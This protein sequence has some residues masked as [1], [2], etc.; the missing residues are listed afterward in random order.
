LT[1]PLIFDATPLIYLVKVSL[2]ESLRK[3]RTPKFL[4]QGVYEELLKGEPL[5]KPEASILRELTEEAAINVIR[6]TDTPFVGRLIKLAA[7]DE[8]KPL[9][10]AEAEAI[11]LA[12]ELGG[13]VISDDRAARSTAKLVHVELHGTGYLLGRMYRESHISKEEAA[14]KVSE[15]RRAGWR[16]SEDDY[17]AILDHL[18]EI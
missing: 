6:P 18:R 11:A 2:A 5:G 9:H 14:T 15:M 13:V 1:G 3:L 12:K 8:R 17:R 4:P 10:R 7:E 16:L